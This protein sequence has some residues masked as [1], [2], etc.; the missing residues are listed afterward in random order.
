MI[1]ADQWQTVI[2]EGES[3]GDTQIRASRE[4]G[5]PGIAAFSH[6]RLIE[7][8]GLLAV[9]KVV[10]CVIARSH[11]EQPGFGKGGASH[12]CEALAG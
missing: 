10:S 5:C 1:A 12:S 4:T 8:D 3:S 11:D 9:V 2:L 6:I 7:L